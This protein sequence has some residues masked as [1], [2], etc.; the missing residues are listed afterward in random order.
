VVGDNVGG[1]RQNPAAL[2]P[3]ARPA[4]DSSAR[5]ADKFVEG[6]AVRR[7]ERRDLVALD[8]IGQNPKGLLGGLREAGPA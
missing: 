1:G 4:S 8:R 6:E 2:R 5:P 3:G 7:K